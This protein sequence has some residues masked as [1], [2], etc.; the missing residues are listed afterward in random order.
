MT[1]T[2]AELRAVMA[3]LEPYRGDKLTPATLALAQRLA[4]LTR[5]EAA[6]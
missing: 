3:L 2:V 1:T 4:R 5:L 6:R